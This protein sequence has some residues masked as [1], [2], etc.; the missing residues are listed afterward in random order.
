[1]HEDWQTVAAPLIQMMPTCLVEAI[2]MEYQFKYCKSAWLEGLRHLL[3]R[4]DWKSSPAVMYYL[5]ITSKPAHE[6]KLFPIKVSF[7]THFL[8]LP[9]PQW[10]VYVHEMNFL[11]FPAVRASVCSCSTKIRLWTVLHLHN[12]HNHEQNQTIHF[13]IPQRSEYMIWINL[14]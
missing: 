2:Q 14:L 8:L 10:C 13:L 6:K 5:I 12:I 7:Y 9:A 4:G 3:E 1:M 11:L